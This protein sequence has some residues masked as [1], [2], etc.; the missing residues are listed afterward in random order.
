MYNVYFTNSTKNENCI[1]M[2]FDKSEAYFYRKIVL[3]NKILILLQF[4]V[5][6]FHIV[7]LSFDVEHFL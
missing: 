7:T 3:I 1:R 2:Y 4:K 6:T 5:N